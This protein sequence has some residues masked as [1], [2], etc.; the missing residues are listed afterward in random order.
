[1]YICLRDIEL[2]KRTA[3]GASI[4]LFL[5]KALLIWFS[6]FLLIGVCTGVGIGV[7]ANLN[8]KIDSNG[9]KEMLTVIALAKKINKS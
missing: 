2:A 5:Y 8:K 9:N 3:I 4:Y 1:M 7:G 6:I